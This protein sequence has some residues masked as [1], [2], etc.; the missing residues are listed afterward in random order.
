[1]FAPVTVA[2]DQQSQLAVNGDEKEKEKETYIV[3]NGTDEKNGN[4]K[5][6]NH[7]HESDYLQE[8]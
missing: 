2:A 1:M 5:E 8:R 4:D 7:K 3:A 6:S